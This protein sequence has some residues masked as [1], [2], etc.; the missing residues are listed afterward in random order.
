[1]SKEDVNDPQGYPPQQEQG[2]ALLQGYAQQYAPRQEYSQAQ[3]PVGGT[4]IV[5]QP[6]SST[7][8][9][10]KPPDYLG[11]SIFICLFCFWPI[12]I[13]SIIYSCRSRDAYTAGDVNTA[14]AKGSTART[15]N[16][17]GL[18]LGIISIIVI[19]VLRVA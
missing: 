9:V 7:M 5:T 11:F 18:V 17:I 1:M 8:Y 6:Q 16:I 2:Y 15:L 3:Y 10:T 12:G 13:A 14:Q 19:M 4:V